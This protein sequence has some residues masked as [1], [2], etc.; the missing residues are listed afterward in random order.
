MRRI[1][2]LGVVSIVSIMSAAPAFAAGPQAYAG[3]SIDPDDFLLGIRYKGFPLTPEVQI[4]PSGEVGFGDFTMVAGNVDIHWALPVESSLAPYLGGG[5]TVN[6]FDFDG[7]SDTEVGG[8]ILGG[9]HFAEKYFT[10]AK[11]GLGDVPDF[12]MYV[13]MGF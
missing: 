5:I 3:F 9:I 11:V 10:E 12:K 6:W 13:G 2:W 8:G 4:V 1:G 7:G